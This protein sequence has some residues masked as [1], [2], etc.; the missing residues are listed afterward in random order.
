MSPAAKADRPLPPLATP[1]FP[2]T[3][4]ARATGAGVQFVPE[5]R[6]C[7]LAKGAVETTLAP[8]I[9]ATVV[10]AE[11]PVTSPASADELVAV[12]VILLNPAPLP[13]K[14][15]T[16]RLPGLMRA[17]PPLKVLDPVKV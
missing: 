7:W 15:P 10:A 17:V 8:R 11:L 9:R 3:S 14:A 6:R 16:N 2:E 13:L 4:V 12:A 5:K 1:R